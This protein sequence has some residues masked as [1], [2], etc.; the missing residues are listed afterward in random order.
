MKW[1]RGSVILIRGML[2]ANDKPQNASDNIPA[3]SVKQS[4]LY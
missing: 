2:V 1:Q 4:M 3:P